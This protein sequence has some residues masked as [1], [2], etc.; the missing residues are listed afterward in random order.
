M[1]FRVASIRPLVRY[2]DDERAVIEVHFDAMPA[3]PLARRNAKSGLRVELAVKG[4]DGFEDDYTEP[5]Q[6]NNGSGHVTFDI[7]QPQLWWPAGMGA[8]PLYELTVSLNVDGH[9]AE[10]R[11]FTIGLASIRRGA[12]D[13]DGAHSDW[14]INGQL[15]SLADGVIVDRTD[16]NNLL[17]VTGDSLLL[18][19]DHYGPELLYDA[20][21]K[22]G[23]L[24]IQCV[25]IH[26]EGVPERE[27]SIEVERLSSHACLAGWFVGHLGRVSDAVARSIRKLDPAHA[28]FRDLPDLDAA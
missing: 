23:I 22:A 18:V 15:C 11:K 9:V 2:V 8:Q 6:L 1:P 12:I 7:V 25:P 20:A 14:L 28:V 13:N 4:M 19:R 21:D 3:L 26:P 24:L 5:L 17:P 10:Q 16:A 27:V